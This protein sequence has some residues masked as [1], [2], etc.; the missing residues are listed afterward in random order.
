MII[1]ELR[2]EQARVT[3]AIEAL[4]AFAFKNKNRPQLGSKLE[5]KLQATVKRRGRPPG[6]RNKPKQPPAQ[7]SRPGSTREWSDIPN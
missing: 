3:K 1:L 6:S 5:S 7:T 2:E 4:E